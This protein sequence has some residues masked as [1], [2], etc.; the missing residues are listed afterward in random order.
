MPLAPLVVALTDG[1]KVATLKRFKERYQE[2]VAKIESDMTDILTALAEADFL[3]SYLG[4]QPEVVE[5]RARRA[6]LDKLEKRRAHIGALL[7]RLGQVIP[8]Q[9]ELH[10]APPGGQVAGKPG[11]R[12]Y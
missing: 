2:E 8:K 12:R 9:A 10:V 7:D 6:E 4:E 5:L 11:L 1:Q 3:A